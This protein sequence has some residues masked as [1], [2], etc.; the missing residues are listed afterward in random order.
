MSAREL[1]VFNVRQIHRLKGLRRRHLLLARRHKGFFFLEPAA[2]RVSV[3]AEFRHELRREAIDIAERHGA[4]RWNLS[5]APNLVSI[6]I[7]SA[8][9][10]ITL[11][12]PTSYA[13]PH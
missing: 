4:L 10:P 5:R 3:L 6:A 1:T 8:V 7:A 9:T 2:D 13:T 12:S 11:R